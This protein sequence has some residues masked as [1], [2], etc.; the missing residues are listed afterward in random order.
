M[1]FVLLL[2]NFW[3]KCKSFDDDQPPFVS[4]H[5][6]SF[7]IPFINKQECKRDVRRKL[8]IHLFEMNNQT[9]CINRHRYNL[10]SQM[11]ASAFIQIYFIYR[12]HGE[13][14]CIGFMYSTWLAL[15][16]MCCAI[17][18]IDRLLNVIMKQVNA[19]QMD[20]RDFSLSLLNRSQVCVCVCLFLWTD[21]CNRTMF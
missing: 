20:D 3:L 14:V 19:N 18:F 17:F 7:S 13:C 2:L 4:S 12:T 8:P 1:Q 10:L 6:V 21:A 11:Y 5:F 16:G 15:Y 9:C